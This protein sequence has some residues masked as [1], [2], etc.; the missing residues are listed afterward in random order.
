MFFTESTMH[1]WNSGHETAELSVPRK[2]STA[3]DTA[4]RKSVG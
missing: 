4:H 3:Q 1:V 2:K